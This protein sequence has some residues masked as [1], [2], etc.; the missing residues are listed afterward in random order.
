METLRK[1]LSVEERKVINEYQECYSNPQ[2]LKEAKQWEK[3]GIESW[4]KYEKDRSKKN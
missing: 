2:M 1:E 3:V 4:L